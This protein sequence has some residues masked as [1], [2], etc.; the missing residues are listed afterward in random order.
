MRYSFFPAEREHVPGSQGIRRD[1]EKDWRTIMAYSILFTSLFPD[2]KDVSLKLIHIQESIMYF[3][4]AYDKVAEIV[5]DKDF[6][7]VR[8]TVK[9]VIAAA[10]RMDRERMDSRR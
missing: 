9:E 8:I 10:R 5:S 3:I 6:S 1:T 4:Q 7:S 2:E